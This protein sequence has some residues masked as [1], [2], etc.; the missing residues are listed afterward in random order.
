MLPTSPLAVYQ[1]DNHIWQF[2]VNRGQC[3]NEAQC[4]PLWWRNWE[5]NECLEGVAKCGAA[6]HPKGAIFRPCKSIN[7]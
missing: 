6:A 1:F 2:G 7:S 3:E 5:L 4:I